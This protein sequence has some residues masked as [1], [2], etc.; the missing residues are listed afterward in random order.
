VT[1]AGRQIDVREEQFANANISMKYRFEFGS[2][3]TDAMALQPAKQRRESP[4]TEE[5]MEID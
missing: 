1:P 3:E 4:R 2:N 5:G